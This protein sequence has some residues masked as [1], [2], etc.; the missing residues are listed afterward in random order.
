MGI[1][2]FVYE[3]NNHGLLEK[4]GTAKITAGSISRSPVFRTTYQYD[5]KGNCVESRTLRNNADDFDIVTRMVYNAD[6]RIVEKFM[7]T[8]GGR[9]ENH[10]A[11]DDKILSELF[12]QRPY[13]LRIQ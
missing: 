6:N 12:E 4:E 13:V 5:E 1:T 3:Y 10:S 2:K 8:E 9:I 7:Y 11:G